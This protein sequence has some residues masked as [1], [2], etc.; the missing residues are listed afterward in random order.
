MSAAASREAQMKSAS[1][2]RALARVT[3][4]TVCVVQRPAGLQRGTTMKELAAAHATAVRALASGP[5]DVMGLSTGGAIALQLAVDHPQLPQRLLIAG[6]AS[7]L[8]NEGRRM[9]RQYGDLIAQGRSGAR[10]LATV[11]A[12]PVLRWPM[13]AL[14]W[15]DERRERKSDPADMLATIDAECGYDVTTRLGEIRAPTLVIAG[16]QDRAF[17]P[18]LLAATAAGIANVRLVLYRGRGHIGAMIDPRFGR[19]VA[20]FLKEGDEELKAGDGKAKAEC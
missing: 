6:M 17:T 11:L 16:E 15:L 1:A 20:A 2:Y 4:R 10:V 19:D 7:W 3:G 12:G 18:E 13:T 14:I 9:L 5:V 8:G